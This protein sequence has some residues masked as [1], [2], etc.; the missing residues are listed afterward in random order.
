MENIKQEIINNLKENNNKMIIVKFG[1]YGDKYGTV[2][3]DPLSCYIIQSNGIKTN[4]NDFNNNLICKNSTYSGYNINKVYVLNK[5][6]VL[7]LIW[8]RPKNEKVTISRLD[9]IKKFELDGDV[10]IEY[11]N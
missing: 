7:E 5:D 1:G 11:I 9:I 4:L 10:E 3:S 6:N 2:I 8:E